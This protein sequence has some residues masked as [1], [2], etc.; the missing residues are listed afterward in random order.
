MIFQ[1]DTDALSEGITGV[2]EGGRAWVPHPMNNL[3]TAR[4][5]APDGTLSQKIQRETASPYHRAPRLLG[6]ATRPRPTCSTT[7]SASTTRNA[8][9]RRWDIW[10]LWSS[11]WRLV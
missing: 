6:H 9:I 7:S 10:A 2:A 3:R 1:F 5:W 8:G 11:K 4:L